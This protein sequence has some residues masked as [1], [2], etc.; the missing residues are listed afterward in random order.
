[1]RTVC[2]FSHVS[3]AVIQQEDNTSELSN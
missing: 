1:M 3:I 2:N